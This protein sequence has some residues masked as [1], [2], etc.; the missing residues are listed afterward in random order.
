MILAMMGVVVPAFAQ[1]TRPPTGA[2]TEPAPETSR[3]AAGSPTE[4]SSTASPAAAR[5]TS[6][7]VYQR[8]AS[9]AQYRSPGVAAALSLTPLPVDFGN[10]YAENI[11]GGIAYTSGELLLGGTMMWMGSSHMCWHDER[12][13]GGWSTTESWTMVGLVTAYVAVKIVAGVQ[14]ASAAEAF[15]QAHGTALL[16]T[17][18]RNGASAGFRVQF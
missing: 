9:F 4:D 2:P 15:N 11:A 1:E 18:D 13:C 10:F 5:Q 12:G 17:G 6:P 3:P 7:E 14:A 16:L 8:E